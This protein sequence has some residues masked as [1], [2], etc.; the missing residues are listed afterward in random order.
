MHVV[1]VYP[2]G[3]FVTIPGGSASYICV[4]TRASDD[5]IDT[6]QWLVNN[7]PLEELELFNPYVVITSQL[8][9]TII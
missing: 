2:P 9:F 6:V 8:S 3:E 7:T 4:L 1:I 5:F